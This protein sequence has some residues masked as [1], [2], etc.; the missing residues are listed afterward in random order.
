VLKAFIF[1]SVHDDMSLHDTL[2]KSES[3]EQA[4]LEYPYPPPEEEEL[5]MFKEVGTLDDW[6]FVNEGKAVLMDLIERA[7]ECR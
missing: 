5:V 3:I 6:T 1:T 4:L 7:N 2:I